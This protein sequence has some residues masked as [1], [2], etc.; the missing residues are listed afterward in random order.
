MWKFRQSCNHRAYDESLEQ[1]ESKKLNTI[2]NVVRSRDHDLHPRANERENFIITKE[3]TIIQGLNCTC[4]L[5]T[6]NCITQIFGCQIKGF[7][8]KIPHNIF[9]GIFHSRNERLFIFSNVEMWCILLNAK[10]PIYR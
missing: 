9:F 3:I 10:G 6:H 8:T 2:F 4:N 5:I 7:C 1:R